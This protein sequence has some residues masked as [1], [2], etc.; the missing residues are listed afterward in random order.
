MNV[1]ARL[2]RK[3]EE[4]LEHIVWS[5]S[6]E[7]QLEFRYVKL[8]KFPILFS[9]EFSKNANVRQTNYKNSGKL[10]TT[11]ITTVNPFQSYEI[12]FKAVSCELSFA[13]QA[14][15]MNVGLGMINHRMG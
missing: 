4:N 9:S 15:P 8:R 5:C 3:H 12:I 11:L 13:L 6:L 10:T 14:V 2:L 1:S 7:T